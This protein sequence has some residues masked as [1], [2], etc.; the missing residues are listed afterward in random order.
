VCVCKNL[1]SLSYPRRFSLPTHTTAILITIA[2]LLHNRRPPL[3]PS[4][5]MPYNIRYLVMA[6]SCNCQIPLLP[7]KSRASTSTV[8]RR[9][10]IYLH[11]TLSLSRYLLT[12]STLAFTRY[13]FNFDAFVCESII[14]L[15]PSPPAMPTLLHILLHDYC[16]IYDPLPTP[17]LHAIDHTILVMAISCKG[18]V[19]RSTI[20]LQVSR[21]YL[22]RA[23]AT[24]QLSRFE[25]DLF[26]SPSLATC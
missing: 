6:I 21:F 14:L 2:R 18:Q 15:L 13:S 12:C 26:A 17:L 16:A 3:R 20:P 4:L 25:L 9:R 23:E 22:N 24:L 11:L 1:S 7:R 5:Y 19:P 10:D 8:P